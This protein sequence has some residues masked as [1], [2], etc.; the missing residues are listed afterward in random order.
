MDGNKGD[1]IN[2]E[3]RCRLVAKEIN[4]GKREDLFAASP[5]LEAKKALFSMA[6]TKGI[7][8]G[9]GQKNMKLEFIDISRAFFHADA[10]VQLPEEDEEEGM[11]AL[12]KKSLYGTRDALQNWE[13]EYSG[14]H[15]E[16]MGFRRGVSSPCTFYHEE[17]DLRVMVHGDDF[18]V[19]GTDEQL[20]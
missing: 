4:T 20:N 6:V 5:P 17:R 3:I 16:K 13:Y 14:Y 11:C 2:L 9:R 8:W 19:L 12:I 15:V 18:T 10:Y 7:G 1:E